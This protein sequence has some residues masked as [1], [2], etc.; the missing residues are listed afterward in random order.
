MHVSIY[1]LSDLVSH[2]PRAVRGRVLSEQKVIRGADILLA[3]SEPIYQYAREL[4]G[5]EKGLYLLPNGFE[6]ELFRK[7]VSLPP[8]YMRI[9]SPRAVFVGAMSGWFDWEL[10]LQVAQLRPE[11]SFCL[12][13]RGEEPSALPGN[14]FFLGARPHEEMPAYLQH[15]DVGLIPFRDCPLVRNIERPLKFYEYIASGLPVVSVPYGNL[16]K[17]APYALFGQT[18]EEFA[19]AIDGALKFSSAQRERLKQEA[20]KFSWENIFIQFDEI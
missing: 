2:F 12:L 8:E 10:L 20:Q 5:T 1:R 17:M 7:E 11:V 9:P 18:P 6:V 14:V 4:R 16:V 15:A 3:A 13:G 19:E